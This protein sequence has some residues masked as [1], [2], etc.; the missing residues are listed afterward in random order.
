MSRTHQLSS[1]IST[2][3]AVGLLAALAP[4]AASGSGDLGPPAEVDETMAPAAPQRQTAAEAAAKS[5]GCVS[6]HTA[7]DQKTMHAGVEIQIGCTDCHGGNA[8]TLRPDGSQSHG[9]AY[10]PAYEEAMRTAHVQPRYPH[11]WERDQETGEPAKRTYTLLNK[12]SPAYV[13][14]IN[15]G[16]LRVADLAC[17]ACHGEI[18]TANRRGLMSTAA[19]FWTGAAYNNGIVPYKR[20]FLGENYMVFDP[21]AEA[22]FG[23][24]AG[25]QLPAGQLLSEEDVRKGVIPAILPLPRWETTP[26]TD[27]FRIFERGGRFIGNLFPEIGLPNLFPGFDDPGKPDARQSNRGL[28]TG[29]R[30]AVPLLNLHKTRL[31][32]PYLWFLGTNDNPGDFR[33]SGCSACHVVYANDRD[34]ISAGV[35][36]KYGHWGQTA[37]VDPTIKDLKGPDGKA[38][39]GHPIKH[40]F[41]RAIPSSTC[42]V[43]HMHQPN[44]FVNPYLGFTMWDYESDAPLMW[45]EKQRYPTAHETFEINSR[46]PEGAAVIGSWGDLDFLSRVWDDVNPKANDTQFADYHG[47]GW[48]FRAV[49]RRARDGSLLDASGSAIPDDLPPAEKWKRAVHMRDIHADAGMQCA[50]CHFSNDSHGNGMMYGE[51]AAAVEIRCRDC[52]GTASARATL[53][54]S[55]PASPNGGND[56]GIITN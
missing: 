14:F 45:P 21:E 9:P 46:N 1:L 40:E 10:D 30:I 33:S 15:P 49:H 27:N 3:V 56:L 6:C 50:D 51:V 12:E 48:N 47:H 32:D 28:G 20:S 44:M 18:V 4:A 39:T 37:T 5:A 16:D 34:P 54:T 17:G 42:M 26:P 11:S 38:E 35:Y 23:E 2:A 52:H 8:Q 13:R 24:P 41:T 31:N 55:G 19:M 22:S 53:R 7:S 25:V 29:A 43:C 36:A